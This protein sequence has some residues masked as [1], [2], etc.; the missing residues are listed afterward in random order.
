LY[1]CLVIDKTTDMQIVKVLKLNDEIV[2]VLQDPLPSVS[3]VASAVLRWVAD[4]WNDDRVR[5]AE[6]EHVN[7]NCQP[8]LDG[9]LPEFWATVSGDNGL[10]EFETGNLP[11]Y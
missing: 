5:N 10:L 3:T 1:I 6:V 8:I 2:A 7:V 4:N 9:D 11:M